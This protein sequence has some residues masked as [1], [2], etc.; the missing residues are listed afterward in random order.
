[1]KLISLFT[2]TVTLAMACLVFAQQNVAPPPPPSSADPSARRGPPDTKPA[3][4]NLPTLWI[5][6]D[7]TVRNGQ[8]DGSNG[9]WG[10]GSVIE[11]YFDT[12][13]INVVNRALGGTSSRTFQ[14]IGKWD[15]VLADAKP[16]DYVLI[17][18]GHNDNIA[19]NDA[20]RARGTI[21]GI[22]DKAEEIDN[23][24]T[25]KHEVVRTYGWYMSKYVKDAKAK[26]MTPIICS[27][28]P[29]CPRPADGKI[30]VSPATQP[31]GYQL[32]SQQVAEREN[33]GYIDLNLLIMQAYAREDA[34][35]LGEKYFTS[36]G[37]FDHTHTNLEGAR[38]NAAQ[39]VEGIK[40]LSDP[41]LT[42]FLKQ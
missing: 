35:T 33:V 34:S 16:G 11:P 39:V 4:P 1:M 25:K 30:T 19:L 15:L 28:I 22:G 29:R 21:K 8:G 32:W 9:Q 20:Q 42:K 13:K 36:N 18:F 27:L 26:G 17:Q 6:G 14:T 24:V 38:L 12:T 40:R 31:S 10:W 3:N 37:K 7:S 23:M 5:V 2:A 41:S